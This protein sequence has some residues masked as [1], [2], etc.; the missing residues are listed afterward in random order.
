MTILV[1]YTFNIYKNRVHWF[2]NNCMFESNSV[3]FLI[4]CNDKNLEFNVPQFSNVSVLKRDDIGFNFGGWS[5]G[6]LTN[7]LYKNYTHFIFANSSI[8]GP[9]LDSSF[10]GKWTDIYINNLINNCKLF[11]STINTIYDPH[12]FAHV[13]SYIF[14]MD[15]E[16]LQFLIDEEIF[17]TRKYAKTLTDEIISKEILMSRKVLDNGWNIGCLLPSYKNVDFTF[18]TQCEND[19]NIF[20]FSDLMSTNYINELWTLNDLTFINC[21]QIAISVNGINMFE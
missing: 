20:L 18:K 9:F 1:I 7:D 17:T 14:S 2:L 19:R 10:T 3:D 11:G 21:S 4:V 6:I 12:L 13:Q 8:V 16:T 5:E 15:L